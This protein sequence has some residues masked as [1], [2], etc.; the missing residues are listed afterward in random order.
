MGGM[1]QVVSYIKHAWTANASM[2]TGIIGRQAFSDFARAA[3]GGNFCA[4]GLP[5]TAALGAP[6]YPETGTDHDHGILE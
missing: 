2:K 4:V 3:R 6:G 1:K 5:G